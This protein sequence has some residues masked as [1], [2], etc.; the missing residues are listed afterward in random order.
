[1]LFRNVNQYIED[2]YKTLKNALS[3]GYIGIKS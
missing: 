1:M 3:V 2:Y